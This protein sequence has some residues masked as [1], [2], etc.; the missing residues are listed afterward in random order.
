MA[1]R[2]KYEEPIDLEIEHYKKYAIAKLHTYRCDAH[3]EQLIVTISLGLN[4]H[5]GVIGGIILG[6]CC[7]VFIEDVYRVNSCD[8]DF[9]EDYNKRQIEFPELS[10]S[11]CRNPEKPWISYQNLWP[12]SE[13]S[14]IPE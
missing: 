6:G 3:G 4:A 12:K 10:R 8:D 11:H 1:D 14:S 5:S 2:V 9:W 7:D 13:A